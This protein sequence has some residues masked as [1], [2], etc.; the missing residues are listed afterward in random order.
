MKTSMP[1]AVKI[2]DK[3]RKRDTKIIAMLRRGLL[4]KQ[5]AFRLKL[6]SVLVVYETVRR[7]NLNLYVLRREI[8]LQKLAKLYPV[9]S[10]V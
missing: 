10:P 3:M 1:Q 6:K 7:N 8:H 4:P 5:I 2:S 9:T